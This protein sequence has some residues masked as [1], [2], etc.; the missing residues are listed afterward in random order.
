L[1][2]GPL[3]LATVSLPIA[4]RLLPLSPV[5]VQQRIHLTCE[6]SACFG[7]VRVRLEHDAS[8]INASTAATN[9]VSDSAFANGR[10]SD[11]NWKIKRRAATWNSRVLTLKV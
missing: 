10:P 7:V 8:L 6:C 9:A 2:T 5:T 11:A 4:W 3:Q 1:D